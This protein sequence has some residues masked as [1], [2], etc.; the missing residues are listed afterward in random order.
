[1]EVHDLPPVGGGDVYTVLYVC[2][3]YNM[4]VCVRVWCVGRTFRTP[5]PLVA[6][7]GPTR[8]HPRGE[9]YALIRLAL[10]AAAACHKLARVRL[11]VCSRVSERRNAAVTFN[12]ENCCWLRRSFP[13]VSGDPQDTYVQRALH[14]IRVCARARV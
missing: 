1:M 13:L 3:V 11:Y 12:L 9:P 6:L 5:F 10:R 2:N 4:C 8:P 14:I 7:S